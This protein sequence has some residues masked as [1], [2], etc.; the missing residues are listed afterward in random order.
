MDALVRK[1][2]TDR[3]DA[4]GAEASAGAVAAFVDALALH[5]ERTGSDADAA[6]FEVTQHLAAATEATAAHQDDT[7][8]REL[9]HRMVNQLAGLAG[10]MR[11]RWQSA[12]AD[13]AT[14]PCASCISQ[15]A[16]LGRLH[17]V[18]G[19]RVEPAEVGLRSHLIGVCE[20][21]RQSF[22]LGERIFID[23]AGPEIGV[24]QAEA[25]TLAL[26][27]NEAVMNAIKHGFPRAGRGWI[28]VELE[29]PEGRL[30]CLRIADNG[31]G[32]SACATPGGG[33]G[34]VKKLAA[35]FGGRVS[36]PPCETGFV[37]EISFD[38]PAGG[39]D[40]VEDA[41]SSGSSVTTPSA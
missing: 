36:R 22:C 17:Q 5:R 35:S 11:Y 31:A 27:V 19:A 39:A 29:A 26:I 4:L 13:G 20:L 37:L 24:S 23:V 14:P 25:T 3:L 30:A 8:L 7:G 10:V 38:P 6:L 2:R 21:L 15:V 18:L 33:L 32:E 1:H 12:L 34:L 9:Q 28:R 16:A 40:P 41:S